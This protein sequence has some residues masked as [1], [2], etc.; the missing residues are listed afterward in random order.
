VGALVRVRCSDLTQWPCA[1]TT[2][3]Q[4]AH[5]EVT[6]NAATHTLWIT[7]P[8]S[9]PHGRPPQEARQ[10]ACANPGCLGP[11][12]L[13]TLA[14]AEQVIRCM[15]CMETGVRPKVRSFLGSQRGPDTWGRLL[16]CAHTRQGLGLEAC[17]CGI[18][19]D[20]RSCC[21]HARASMLPHLRQP[22][23]LWPGL[24]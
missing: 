12:P 16:W 6:C 20:G 13:L 1:V 23:Y 9:C 21:A 8:A 19:A 5:V 17:A 4:R 18:A 11:G 3:T 24:C 2:H 10:A 14:P 15:Q 7:C 22:L